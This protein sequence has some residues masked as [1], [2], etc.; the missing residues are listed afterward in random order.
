MRN[1]NFKLK[2]VFRHE[3]CAKIIFIAI[4]IISSIYCG[5]LGAMNSFNIS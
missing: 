5:Y 2:Y 4:M 3:N 1:F